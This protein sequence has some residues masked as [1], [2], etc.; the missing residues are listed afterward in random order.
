MT[1]G[2]YYICLLSFVWSASPQPLPQEGRAIVYVIWLPLLSW[3][4]LYTHLWGLVV[5][6][7]L[8]IKKRSFLMSIII[9]YGDSSL[10]SE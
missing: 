7:E 5:D 9:P 1:A 4:T 6:F 2:N 3:D 10:R 8:F